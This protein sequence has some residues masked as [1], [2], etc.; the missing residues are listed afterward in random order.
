MTRNRRRQSKS[1]VPRRQ[2]TA[3][4]ADEYT[5]CNTLIEL[6]EVRC[7]RHQREYWL[8]LKQYK[9]HSQLVDTLDASAC[10]TRRA[11]KRLQSSEEALQEL[12][13]L[14]ELI[15]A[16]SMEIEGREA[17]TRRFFQGISDER[18]MSWVEGREDRRAE[19]MKL[20]NAL[21][22][23]LELLKLR[24]GSVQQ[25]PWRA[26]KQYVSSASSRP[27]PSPSCFVQPRRTQYRPG[28]ES[29]QSEAI[30]DMWLKVIGVMV[31]ALNSR[32]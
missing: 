29:S 13:V 31:S 6:S 1:T 20:R 14:D 7:D 22:A 3:T 21:M 18:H 26:L 19:A 32:S 23:R 9:K 16:L 24:E 12:E 4:L 27:S 8:S 5:A 17:H 15:E 30:N 2:C 25:D 10:L 11:V 28:Y